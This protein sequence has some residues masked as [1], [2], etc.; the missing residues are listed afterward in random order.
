MHILCC[1]GC[2][3]KTLCRDCRRTGSRCRGG[4]VGS[5]VV[6]SSRPSFAQLLLRS[7]VV[8]KS[9]SV[10]SLDSKTVFHRCLLSPGFSLAVSSLRIT[11]VTLV[12]RVLD[13][14]HGTPPPFGRPQYALLHA[15]E[16]ARVTDAPTAAL[17]SDPTDS[18]PLEAALCNILI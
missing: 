1:S 2:F 11:Q 7:R 13:A 15:A 3:P 17:R 18:I 4:C 16:E 5:I 14:E 8:R 6:L 10:R 9:S 12:G